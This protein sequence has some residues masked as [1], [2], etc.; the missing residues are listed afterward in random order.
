MEKQP[1]LMNYSRM[2]G[3]YEAHLGEIQKHAFIS[4]ELGMFYGIHNII[5][6]ILH[7]HKPP[8][9]FNDFRVGLIAKGR[10]RARFNLVEKDLR[11]GTLFFVGPGAILQP[12]SFSDELE[13]YGIALFDDFPM[14]Q[15]P[16]AFNGQM[17]DFQVKADDDDIVTARLIFDTLWHLV[18]QPD[19]HR[20]TVS[21][22]VAALMHLY[23]GAYHRQS[24]MLHASQSREQTIFDSFIQLVNQH[25]AEQH[26]IGYYAERLCLTQR[27]LSTV[28]HRTSGVTAKEWID[29]ALIA[30]IKVELMY[31][32]K[33]ILQISEELSF[34][35]PSFFSKYFKRING[36]TPGEYRLG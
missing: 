3:V 34:P 26:Q 10:A 27:Y 20:Q 4:N 12:I 14:P 35:T 22:L 7:Q 31:T 8:F 16:S 11:P 5:S 25:C 1:Q 13:I 30:R 15:L 28:I 21:S 19:Y 6:L 9:V 18:H 2:K 36:I 24:D 33:T 32:D 23:D 17:R 29:R